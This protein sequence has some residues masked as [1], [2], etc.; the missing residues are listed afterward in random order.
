MTEPKPHFEH[1]DEEVKHTFQVDARLILQLGRDSIKDHTTA[2]IELVKN[3][4][5]ADAKNVAI[6]IQQSANR[7]RVADNGFGMTALEIWTNWL[8]IGFSEKR[9]IKKSKKDRRKTGEKGIGRIATDRLGADVQVISMAANNDPVGLKVNWDE[10]DVDNRA[11]NDIEI[12]ALEAPFISLPAL[13][14]QPAPHGT[15]IIIDNLRQSWNSESIESLYQELSILSSPFETTDDFHIELT[16]DVV[17]GY[18]KKIQS[19]YYEA[20]EIDLEAVYDDQEEKVLYTIKDKYTKGVKT[21]ITPVAKL[22]S[23]IARSEPRKT[24]AC[25]PFRLRL[26]FFPRSAATVVGT[27]LSLSDL[28]QYLDKNAGVRVYRDNISV[29][30]YGY[31]ESSFGSDWLGLAERKAAEPAGI[32]R[33]TFKV[34]SHQVVGSV[35]IGRDTN[36]GLKDSAA[37]EGLVENDA[38]KDLHDAVMAAVLLLESH[39]HALNARLKK[40]EPQKPQPSPSETLKKLFSELNSVKARLDAI[41]LDSTQIDLLGISNSIKT[42]DSV[43][44]QTEALFDEL[45]DEKRVLSGLATLGIASAV[46]GHETQSAISVFRDSSENTKDYLNQKPPNLELAKA[47]LLTATKHARLIASWGAFALSRVQNEKRKKRKDVRIHQ[48]VARTLK[49][50]RPALEA[51]N[52]E[53]VPELETIMGSAFIMDLESVFLNLMT[54]AYNACLHSTQKRIIKIILQREN[55]E[56][57]KGFNLIVSDSGPGVAQEHIHRI[58]DP[59][60]S[61]KLGAKKG[62]GGTG[63]GLTIVKSIVEESGGFASVDRDPVLGG[64]RFTIWLPK[65]D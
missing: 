57:R 48:I 35:F 10:F 56:G 31:V 43:V 54:N 60:F 53:A 40:S 55:K 58:W 22:Y 28:R 26:L 15:E 16:T 33:E 41:R 7:I 13:D 38:F 44:Q 6:D 50:I 32:S 27:K 39:R 59:L 18:S 65:E 12:E 8:R 17:H 20:A 46:F 25:G 62:T 61:T 2:L 5:D 24:L 64:A 51:S 9:T 42:V 63:L 37:R 52:I 45:L 3:S 14:N 11:I 34:A 47:E 1:G 19:A 4:Y 23:T 49:E 36:P 29:K 30:P 21:E